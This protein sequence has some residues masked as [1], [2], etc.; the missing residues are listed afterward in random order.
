M[1][2]DKAPHESS[3]CLYYTTFLSLVKDTDC[4]CEADRGSRNRKRKKKKT[5]ACDNKTRLKQRSMRHTHTQTLD[6]QK[7]RRSFLTGW[8]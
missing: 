6:T 2:L 7:D 3:S 4:N 5:T 1:C 8:R